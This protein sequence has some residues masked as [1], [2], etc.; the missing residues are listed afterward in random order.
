MNNYT[1]SIHVELPHEGI[2]HFPVALTMSLLIDSVKCILMLI[3]QTWQ[4]LQIKIICHNSE[5]HPKYGY[6]IDSLRLF[7]CAEMSAN[8]CSHD[9]FST[10][11][12]LINTD[13]AGVTLAYGAVSDYNSVTS[14]VIQ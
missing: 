2:N 1:V 12:V 9:L 11:S 7:E 4:N 6:A 8:H 5:T 3:L 14:Y 10:I 13:L